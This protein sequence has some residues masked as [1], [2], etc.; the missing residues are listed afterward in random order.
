MTQFKGGEATVDRLSRDATAT[1]PV[2]GILTAVKVLVQNP[3]TSS[4][5]PLK[6]VEGPMK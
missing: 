6:K 3:V 1:I 5:F 4:F 2:C